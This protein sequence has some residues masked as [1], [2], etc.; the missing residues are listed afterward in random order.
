MNYQHH[1][2]VQQAEYRPPLSLLTVIIRLVMGIGLSVAGSYVIALVILKVRD[3]FYNPETL[4]GFLVLVPQD[5]VLRTMS[6]NGQEI[7]LPLASFHFFT[8]ALALM[9]FIVAGFL[10]GSLLKR[11]ISLL[12]I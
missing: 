9:L 8:Y 1:S 7:I 3:T 12:V 5:P 11:G 6:Y 4:N 10:G 2:Q